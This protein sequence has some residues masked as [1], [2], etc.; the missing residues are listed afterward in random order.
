VYDGCDIEHDGLMNTKTT[1]GKSATNSDLV[2]TSRDGDQFHYHWAAR[3]C[4]SLLPGVSDLVAISIEGASTAEG[5]GSVLE[6]DELI[7]VGFY[8]GSEQLEEARL[9]RYV[10]LRA[11]LTAG[12][13]R[14]FNFIDD[15]LPASPHECLIPV[16]DF[17]CLFS[18]LIARNYGQT[19]KSVP[20]RSRTAYGGAPCAA[21]SR[22]G[23]GPTL[24][25]AA[26]FA[27]LKHPDWTFSDQCWQRGSS[28][29]RPRREINQLRL[30]GGSH[31]HQ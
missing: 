7:D 14:V 25:P 23:L 9:V 27:S 2:R 18:T 29:R 4:L 5:A 16:F 21:A 20:E 13:S 28:S 1:V 15:S 10:Q 17:N 30:G 19:I 8:Y 22:L 12:V 26:D 31:P 3:H 11:G 24:W 6:G